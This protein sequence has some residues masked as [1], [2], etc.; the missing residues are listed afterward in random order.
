LRSDLTH[1][2]RQVRHAPAF[3][4]IFVATIALGLGASL[5]IF[6]VI[7]HVFVQPPDVPDASRLVVLQRVAPFGTLG[8]DRYSSDTWT[9]EVY[10]NILSAS[11]VTL[12]ASEAGEPLQ[13]DLGGSISRGFFV[14][15]ATA[16]DLLLL[17][18]REQLFADV[19]RLMSVLNEDVPRERLAVGADVSQRC[20]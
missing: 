19:Q 17:R 7:D 15:L 8:V 18:V 4:A 11:T 3:A 14:G 12:A 6:M 13:V 1:A 2:L 20:A 5:T 10:Q 16:R 9:P